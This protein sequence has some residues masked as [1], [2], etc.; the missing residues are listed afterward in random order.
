M[1][2]GFQLRRVVKHAAE[3]RQE[4]FTIGNLSYV[5]IKQLLQ[6]TL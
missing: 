2:T 1:K 5:E 6:L 4:K 3:E